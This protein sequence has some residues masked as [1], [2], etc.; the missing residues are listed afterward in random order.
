MG[1]HSPAVVAWCARCLLLLSSIL[2][3]GCGELAIKDAAS[4][5][6]PTL[7]RSEV[8]GFLAGL[9]TTVAAVPDLLA[10]LKKRSGAGMNP[11]M[12]AIMCVFQVVW[13]YY[14]LLIRS[15]PVIGWN[16]VAVVINSVSVGAYLHF[17]RKEQSR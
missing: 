9:A 12:A 4:L 7:Q 8:V 11:R 2:L 16:L 3:V 5:F 13:I 6:A 14:G 15:R 17:V 10:M 1:R